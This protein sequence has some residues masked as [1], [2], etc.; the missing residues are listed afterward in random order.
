MKYLEWNNLIGSCI[1]NENSAGKEVYL[2][3]TKH[4]IIKAGKSISN[5]DND[6][7]ESIWNDFVQALRV[8]IPGSPRQC[9]LLEKINATYNKRTSLRI[10]EVEVLYPPYI[11]YLILTTLPILESTDSEKFD[12]LRAN[13]YYARINNFL[14][15][16]RLFELQNQ[17]HN[18]N[19]NHIWDHLSQWSIHNK[20][21][22]LGIFRVR[23]FS[24]WK[25]VGIPMSQCLIDPK[26]FKKLPSLFLKE[27]LIPNSLINDKAWS[28]FL[29]R[30]WE[31]D[32]QQ[33]RVLEL[34]Q[35]ENNEMMRVV[36]EIVK[37]AYN[38]WK[39][40]TE[41]QDEELTIPQPVKRIRKEGTR[42]RL[43]LSFKLDKNSGEFKWGYR[44]FSR[45][46]YPE[47][48]SF[49]GQSCFEA[50]EN[51]SNQLVFNFI[52][53]TTL[54]DCSNKWEAVLP[55]KDLR[56]FIGGAHLNLS[57]DYWIETDEIN[58]ISPMRILCKNTLKSLIEKWGKH[59]SHPGR[60]KEFSSEDY[61]GIPENWSLFEFQYPRESPNGEKIAF[62]TGSKRVFL[63]NGIKLGSRTYL[64]N[65]LPEV[66]VENGDG[67]EQ[68]ILELNQGINKII[69]EKKSTEV[70][71]WRLPQTLNEGDEFII[72]IEGTEKTYPFKIASESINLLKIENQASPRRNQFGL[73]TDNDNECFVQGSLV[74][75][76]NYKRQGAYEWYFKPIQ[77][78]NASANS[79]VNSD[80]NL[81]NDLLLEFL[82]RK[83]TSHLKEF[84]E[85]FEQNLY[86]RISNELEDEK[87][88][89][90]FLK[91]QIVNWYDFL[92][93]VDFDYLSKRITVNPPQMFLVPTSSGR[94]AILTGARTPDF[95]EK[96]FE[97]SNKLGLQIEIEP[98]AGEEK[99]WIL[100]PNTI[101]VN[102]FDLQGYGARELK[103]FADSLNIY[104]APE[105]IVQWGLLNFSAGIDDYEKSIYPDER[106]EDWDWSRKIFNPD[107][108][109][110]ERCESDNFDKTFSLVE[111]QLN[112]YTYKHIL[113]KDGYA[114]PV[115]KSWGRWL[116]LKHFE[117]KV[118]FNSANCLTA[119]PTGMPL[120]RLISE[121]LLL[122]SGKIPRQKFLEING[123]KTYFNLY[124]NLVDIMSFNEFLKIGQPLIYVNQNF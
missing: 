36:L 94:K 55:E 107:S 111:Y 71:R 49:N 13:N 92:G 32:L 112:A 83:K 22:D 61:D 6:N 74:H 8:G 46:D 11:G 67:S 37:Q 12:T 21:T 7:E 10:D 53:K 17:N 102:A 110:F 100:L 48:L 20:K 119:I 56:Y 38:N 1:F 95:V 9:D 76:L 24:A 101:F 54:K 64:K 58:P 34:F 44:M 93:Y 123:I 118:I 97:T 42:S 59:F 113:W 117:K 80:Y 39:G 26:T 16:H 85:A 115:D 73:V 60:F 96:I 45:N 122:L 72:S 88:N 63:I 124:D 99:P 62:D 19:W 5:F 27:G 79:I 40:E 2:F 98:Q 14:K 28:S 41:I 109:R 4:D 70:I 18:K 114:F 106:F 91:R 68:V 25:Y 81:K 66:V 108:F 75:G 78:N 47:D 116:I 31:K 33:R 3:L 89:L 84:F 103:I 57:A 35:K 77:R 15:K 90:T 69:L 105:Q 51:W 104:F 43:F 82:T 23:N 30:T 87:V 29:E 120:P 86:S 121:A 65:C 52:E 50:R